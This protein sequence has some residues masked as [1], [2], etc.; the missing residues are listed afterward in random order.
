[1][2]EFIS[3]SFNYS[4]TWN[5]RKSSSFKKAELKSLNEEGNRDRDIILRK[6][7]AFFKREK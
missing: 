6:I 5:C 4:N 3:S 7:E 1:M 2:I